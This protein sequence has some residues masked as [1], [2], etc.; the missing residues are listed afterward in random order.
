MTGRHARQRRTL[1][2]SASW[3][4]QIQRRCFPGWLS[5]AGCARTHLGEP[6]RPQLKNDHA[7]S[8]LQRAGRAGAPAPRALA[9]LPLV[10]ASVEW[11]RGG[12]GGTRVST[13]W[14][15]RDFIWA[16]T[17]QQAQISNDDTSSPATGHT[18]QSTT[19]HRRTLHSR[20]RDIGS[21]GFVLRL[22]LCICPAGQAAQGGGKRRGSASAHR[23]GLSA[24]PFGRRPSILARDNDQEQQATQDPRQEAA[25]WGWPRHVSTVRPAASYP[26]DIVCS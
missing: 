5:L 25:T 10:P 16:S 21:A 9:P 2:S 17:R 18:F 15:S 6:R 3:P 1:V 24:A 11:W 12:G 19:F 8:L 4:W 26:P 22:R 7:A 20:R 14:N 23:R 13:T